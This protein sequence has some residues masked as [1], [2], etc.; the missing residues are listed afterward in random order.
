MSKQIRLTANVG[1]FAPET[2]VSHHEYERE[3]GAPPHSSDVQTWG[4]ID[5][6]QATALFLGAYKDDLE[7]R[8]TITPDS[9]SVQM[10]T[11]TG[12]HRLEHRFKQG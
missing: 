3:M 10:Y 5:V 9:C 4:A 11:P 7:V 8:V 6:E 2:R 1:P 12:Q